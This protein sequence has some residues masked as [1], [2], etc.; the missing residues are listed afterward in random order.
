MKDVFSAADKS[1]YKWQFQGSRGWRDMFPEN[2][3]K[4]EAAYLRGL[5]E[6]QLGRYTWLNIQNP[7]Y[8]RQISDNDTGRR[9]RRIEK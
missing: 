6:T 7:D 5:Q 8:A 4:V 9:I 2:N 1:N 3:Q